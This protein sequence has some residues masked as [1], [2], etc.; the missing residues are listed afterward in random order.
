MNQIIGC[1][2]LAITLQKEM[3]TWHNEINRKHNQKQIN[4]HGVVFDGAISWSFGNGF[5]RNVA[6]VGVDNSSPILTDNDDKVLLYQVK[7]QLMI[8]MIY[9]QCNT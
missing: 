6:I 1:I 3:F 5:A 7:D 8:L 9:V 4:G 2:I